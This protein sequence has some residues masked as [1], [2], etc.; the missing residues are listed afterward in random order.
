MARK[1]SDSFEQQTIS[2]KKLLLVEG[3]NERRFFVAL[4]R[5]LELSEGLQVLNYGEK[6]SYGL[7]SLRCTL[8]QGIQT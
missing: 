8:P 5:R 1:A 2:Q 6:P 3:E 4:L 7:C